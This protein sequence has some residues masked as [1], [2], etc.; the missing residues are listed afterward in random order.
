MGQS[1]AP[2]FRGERLAHDTLAVSELFSVGRQLRSFRRPD[3]KALRDEK[4]GAGLVFDLVRDPGET[5]PLQDRNL[6]LARSSLADLQ[7]GMTWVNQFRAAMPVSPSTPRLP[8]EVR[9]QLES[10]GYIDAAASPDPSS[11]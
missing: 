10:L 3:R 11:D 8:E 2:L 4:V 9:Q 7:R 6:P 5:Q 1:L